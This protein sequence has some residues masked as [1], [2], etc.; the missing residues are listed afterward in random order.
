MRAHTAVMVQCDGT[1]VP[2]V[3]HSGPDRY[4]VNVGDLVHVSI[5]HE[6]GAVLLQGLR[7]MAPPEAAP[8]TQLTI[9]TDS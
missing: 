8:A 1:E 6:Q 3:H 2:S 9:Y 7:R 4:V 5:T